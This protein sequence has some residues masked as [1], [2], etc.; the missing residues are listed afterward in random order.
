[1]SSSKESWATGKLFLNII[2]LNLPWLLGQYHISN[3]H[4]QSFFL[5]CWNLPFQITETGPVIAQMR[6]GT[7]VSQS[8]AKLT[9]LTSPGNGGCHLYPTSFFT[10][11][12]NF[13][14]QKPDT[15]SLIT[16]SSAET[17]Y[18]Y[19][20][21]W[22]SST[23]GINPIKDES[24]KSPSSTGGNKMGDKTLTWLTHYKEAILQNTQQ[25]HDFCQYWHMLSKAF[26]S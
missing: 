4:P 13:K 16:S 10:I 7:S 19:L 21:Y 25:R 18:L 1:M 2:Q 8:E 17:R 24:R 23:M 3:I 26:K 9:I 12:S 5:H 6:L 20:H 11:L 14:C 15:L 22:A